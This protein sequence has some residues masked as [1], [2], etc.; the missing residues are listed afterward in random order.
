M[1]EYRLWF[2]FTHIYAYV[3]VYHN[4]IHTNGPGLHAIAYILQSTGFYYTNPMVGGGE[5]KRK[6]YEIKHGVIIRVI[7]LLLLSLSVQ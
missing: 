1:Y 6:K 5:R 3:C 2:Y 7:L 4:R